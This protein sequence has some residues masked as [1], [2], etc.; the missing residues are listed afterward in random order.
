[1]SRT[2]LCESIAIAAKLPELGVTVSRENRIFRR[3]ACTTLS[4]DQIN[5]G[6]NA[7]DDLSRSQ[8]VTRLAG[9]A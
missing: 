6:N 3:R 5:P 7:R 4:Q 1:L 8:T 2:T 9:V